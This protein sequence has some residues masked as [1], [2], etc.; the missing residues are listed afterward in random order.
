M[1]DLVVDDQQ[2]IGLAA[3]GAEFLL[4]D[5]AEHVA[6]V[7]LGG[8]FEVAGHLAPAGVQDLDLDAVRRVDR[9]DQPGEAAPG[10][11]ELAQAGGV[12]DGVDLGGQEGID[13]GDIAVQRAA[14]GGGIARQGIGQGGAEP[15][16]QRGGGAGKEG[17]EIIG[18]GAVAG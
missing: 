3:G 11:L 8:A 18:L 16:Q 10:A 17:G 4:V 2:S 12:Q 13:G 6:L 14:Q 5:L 15:G 1:A 7:E 9:L